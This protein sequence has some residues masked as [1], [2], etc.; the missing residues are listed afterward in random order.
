MRFE[1]FDIDALLAPGGGNG[2]EYWRDAVR[3]ARECAFCTAWAMASFYIIRP[4]GRNTSRR[5]NVCDDPSRNH[6]IRNDSARGRRN[7]EVLEDQILRR[8]RGLTEKNSSNFSFVRNEVTRLPSG[9]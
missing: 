1:V 9:M 2:M 3:R 8:R 7:E 5:K 4:E 6:R